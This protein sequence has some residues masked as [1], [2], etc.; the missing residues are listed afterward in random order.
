MVVL[1]FII[2][3][4]VSIKKKLTVEMVCFPFY[5]IFAALATANYAFVMVSSDAACNIPIAFSG[6]IDNSCILG[7]TASCQAIAGTTQ[8]STII[9]SSNASAVPIGMV[10]FSEFTAGTCQA[11]ETA[12]IFA[13]NVQTCITP[14]GAI[15]FQIGCT[16]S[17]F[18]WVL[19]NNAICFGTAN[20]EVNQN[21][22]FQ[23][24]QAVFASTSKQ[25]IGNCD[26]SATTTQASGT[27]APS[28]AVKEGALYVMVL[29][30]VAFLLS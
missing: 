2:F 14:D 4:I 30:I 24:C 6:G 18:F 29:L 25:Q 9:C 3:Q 10:S 16:G 19:W 1:F 28:S 7:Q 20:K 27:T 13:A 21:P 22:P 15:S 17:T 11:N 12:N 26:G 5:M 23:G 8:F